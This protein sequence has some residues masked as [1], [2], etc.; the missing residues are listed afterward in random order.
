MVA[1]INRTYLESI[2]SFACVGAVG[3]VADAIALL[4]IEQVDLVLLDIFMPASNGLDF[5]RYLRQRCMGVDVIVISAASDIE[6]IQTALR[7]G[8]VDYLIKPFEFRRF[9]NALQAYERE[10]A[11]L[12]SGDTLSQAQLDRL[13]LHQDQSHSVAKSDIPKGMT[14]STLQRAVEQLIAEPDRRFSTE[15]WARKV[16][17][18][19]VSM[20]KYARFLVDLGV[21]SCDIDYQT[22]GRPVYRYR[23]VESNVLRMDAYLPG[24]SS[25]Q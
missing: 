2:A 25:R 15:E 1:Q 24:W 13:I 11:L 4:E 20:R 17:I 10:Q 12:K 19:R 14:R 3:S 5:L 6:H 7:L 21:V 9:K 22:A 18:S 23:L 8:A 16:G